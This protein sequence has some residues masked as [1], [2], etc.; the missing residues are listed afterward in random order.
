MKKYFALMLALIV[1]SASF[2]QKENPFVG[3]WQQVVAVNQA[4]VTFGPSGKVFMDDGRVFGYSLNPADFDTY[5]EFNFGP[6]MFATYEVT[7]DSTY[8][9]Q[10]SLHNDT[11]WEGTIYFHYKFLN[12]RTLMAYYDHTNPDGS[13]QTIFD[14]WIKAVYDPTEQKAIL[15]KVADNW[16]EYVK[17]AKIQYNRQ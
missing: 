7:S 6:W 1:S 11:G 17:Q 14:L 15:K 3:V 9:E 12:S 5:E 13:V 16:D 8:T 4:T 10:V 2:A